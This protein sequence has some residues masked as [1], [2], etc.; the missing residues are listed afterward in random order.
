[1]ANMMAPKPSMAAKIMALAPLDR[2][3]GAD[4]SKNEGS[5]AGSER[6]LYMPSDRTVGDIVILTRPSRIPEAFIGT[7]KLLEIEIHLNDPFIIQLFGEDD[8]IDG[9]RAIATIGTVKRDPFT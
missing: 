3:S 4:P 2:G 5:G 6:R 7:I 1:M 8:T 9:A